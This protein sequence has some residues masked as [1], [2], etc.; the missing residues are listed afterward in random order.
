MRLL[1]LTVQSHMPGEH[2]PQ[3]PV[4]SHTGA[5]PLLLKGAAIRERWRVKSVLWQDGH[6]GVSDE[7]TRVSNSWPHLLQS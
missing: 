6:D 7:R 1:R 2:M 4:P 5:S 3:L